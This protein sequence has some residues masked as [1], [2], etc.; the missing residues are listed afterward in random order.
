MPNI[1]K[2]VPLQT[3]KRTAAPFVLSPAASLRRSWRLKHNARALRFFEFFH[4]RA[5]AEQ[6]PISVDI[7]DARDCG[8][9]FVLARPRGRESCLVAG[10]RL[11][12]FVGS[13]LLRG[14]R[15]VLEQIAFPIL[16]S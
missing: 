12:P 9:E 7:V 11:V 4:R 1:T 6:I 8:P 13:N 16:F 2:P 14:V 10:I 15:R 3:R 5:R